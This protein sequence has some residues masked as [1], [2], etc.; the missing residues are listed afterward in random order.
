MPVFQLIDEL[1]FPPPHLA[2]RNGLL[3]VGGDLRPERLILAYRM[4]IFPWYE[5]GEPILWWSPDPRFVLFPEEIK[6]SRSMR[7]LLK[8]DLFRVSWDEAFTAVVEGCRAP[9]EGQRGTWITDEMA[10]AYGE[11]HRLGLA[12]SVEVW[13]GGELVGGLYGV[14]LGRC[15]FGESMFTRVSNASK[16]ALIHL[17]RRLRERG[18]AVIDC[19]IY[20]EHLRTMGARMIP[21]V[22]FLR[23]IADDAV[24]EARR[25]VL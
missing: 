22:E 19:Q 5:E 9:R 17:A 23:I 14:S 20:T 3:A 7:Q 11:L 25:R 12:H 21:R 4:G 6:I 2:E 1:I 8:K 18:Y 13:M 10:A 15:F 24:P 16:V